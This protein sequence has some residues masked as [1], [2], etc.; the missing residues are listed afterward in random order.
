M[1]SVAK[2]FRKLVKSILGFN[3][4][5]PSG[6]NV[7]WLVGYELC[8]WVICMSCH[9]LWGIWWKGAGVDGSRWRAELNFGRLMVSSCCCCWSTRPRGL[10]GS[11][12]AGD[13]EHYGAADIREKKC[14]TFRHH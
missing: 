8:R 14:H 9:F 1:G 2:L 13:V 7:G 4:K 10:S 6:P 12:P 3:F 11:Y 5:L